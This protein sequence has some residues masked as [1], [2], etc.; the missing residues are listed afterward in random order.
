[1][2]DELCEILLATDTKFSIHADI[3]TDQKYKL[4]KAMPRVKAMLANKKWIE[5]MFL[6]EVC[7]KPEAS[8]A[9]KIWD[10]A[11]RRL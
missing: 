8:V 1:M 7:Y 9:S 6:L 4:S 11:C 2:Q 10:R 3:N 5:N